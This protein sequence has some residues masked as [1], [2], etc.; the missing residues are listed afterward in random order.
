MRPRFVPLADFGQPAK[1][2]PAE[3]ASQPKPIDRISRP[4]ETNPA[5]SASQP[6]PIRRNQPAKA[7]PAESAGQPKPI[8]RNQPASRNQ[9]GGISQPA[10]TNPAESASQPR[11]QPAKAHGWLAESAE[12]VEAGKR[13]AIVEEKS[14]YEGRVRSRKEMRAYRRRA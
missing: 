14:G 5:E 7:N 12:F 6:K 3:S 10:E 13:W 2:N 4:A 1:T 11:N 9:F 8:P